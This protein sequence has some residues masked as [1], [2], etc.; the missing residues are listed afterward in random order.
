MHT[1]LLGTYHKS[2]I[3]TRDLEVLTRVCEP[4]VCS[5]STST[6]LW[7]I[8][9]MVLDHLHIRNT[10][11]EDVNNTSNKAL[12]FER[13]MP[14]SKTRHTDRQISHRQWEVFLLLA[15]ASVRLCVLMK[16]AC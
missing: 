2:N 15:C 11:P 4:Y 6:S 10:S 7:H 9:Q 3:P 16:Q 8:L 14:S 1:H 5:V 12:L 13:P